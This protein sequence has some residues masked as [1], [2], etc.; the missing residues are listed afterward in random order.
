MVIQPYRVLWLFSLT[1]FLFPLSSLPCKGGEEDI[2]IPEGR[3]HYLN[4]E[5]VVR[6]AV[7]NPDII[8]VSPL[9]QGEGILIVGKK[10]GTTDLL[11]WRKGGV[12]SHIVE[13]TT[14]FSLRGKEIDGNLKKLL[15]E[16]GIKN[17]K[18]THVRGERVVTGEGTGVQVHRANALI[19]KFDHLI[20]SLDAGKEEKREILFDLRFIEVS[21]GGLEKVGVRWPASTPLFSRYGN[22][23]DKGLIL[24]TSLDLAIEHLQSK[25]LGRILANP[26]L[27]CEEGKRAS[28]HGGG[29]IPIIIIG[30]G[31]REVQWKNYGIILN[32]QTK[33]DGKGFLSTEVD[34]EVSTIDHSSGTGDIPGFITR[35]VNTSFS[36]SP[37]QTIILSGLVR[38][39]MLK[40]VSKFP[41][42]GNIPLIGELFKSRSFREDRSELIIT[43][44]PSYLDYKISR[45]LSKSTR[46]NYNKMDEEMKFN[47]LD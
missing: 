21:R 3:Q 1:L 16:M 7:G 32:L 18:I 2:I 15:R 6:I 28:F 13:V 29:E 27:V 38:S 30:D 33:R 41:L 22:R 19:G 20:S 24:T 17:P 5:G 10:E 4:I 31:K 46:D 12:E 42:F 36:V 11:L 37:G 26:I 25:G 35:K 23:E 40:D 47:L 39:E 34:A 14:S 45:D 9:K 43:I 44:T 8:S